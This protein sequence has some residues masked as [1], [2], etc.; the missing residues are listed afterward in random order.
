MILLG[1]PRLATLWTRRDV[2][3]AV[4]LLSLGFNTVRTVGPALGGHRG[5]LIR[6]SDGFRRNHAHLSGPS[7]HH[8]AMQAEGSVLAS[9]A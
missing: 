3:A 4:T 5:C 9:P 8:M 1:R 6:A 7:G 2:P